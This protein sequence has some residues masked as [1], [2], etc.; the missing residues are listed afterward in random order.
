ML[1]LLLFCLTLVEFPT[2]HYECNYT[3]KELFSVDLN[4]QLINVVNQVLLYSPK[5]TAVTGHIFKHV[6]YWFDL[7]IPQENIYVRLLCFS[8]KHAPVIA[9]LWEIGNPRSHLLEIAMG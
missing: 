1:V 4:C 8:S 3:Y 9:I 2:W 7:K 6:S 5:N